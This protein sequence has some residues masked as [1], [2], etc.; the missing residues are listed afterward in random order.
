MKTIIGVIPRVMNVDGRSLLYISDLVRKLILMYDCYPFL[1]I[2]PKNVDYAKSSGT[3]IGHMTKEEKTFWYKQLDMCDGI[4]M[5]GGKRQYEFD[6]LTYEYAVLKDIPLLGICMGMQVMCNTDNSTMDYY[7]VPKKNVS[8]INHYVPD[9]SN[10]HEVTIKRNSKLYHIV[11]TDKLM[12]NSL[13]HFHIEKV[14]TLKVSALSSDGYIEAVEIPNKR[15]IVGVQWHP[16]MVASTDLAN[17]K[18][19]ECFIKTAKEVNYEKSDR[20]KEYI[21]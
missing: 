4:L 5:T 11:H 17:K 12:V 9:S 2:P 10:C 6:R 3:D 7:D 14:N 1:I 19:I 21:R 18:I 15:F 8:H 16:E 20:R 13:H